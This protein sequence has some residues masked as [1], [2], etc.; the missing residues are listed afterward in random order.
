MKKSKKTSETLDLERDL[1]TTKE[2]INALRRAGNLGHANSMNY[3]DFLESAAQ[4][5]DHSFQLGRKGPLGD[6]PFELEWMFDRMK[7]EE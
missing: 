7:T 5:V 3:L 2:D 4:V 6:K 1:P